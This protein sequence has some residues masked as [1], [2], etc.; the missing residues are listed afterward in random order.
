[1]RSKSAA[2]SRRPPQAR[3]SFPDVLHH[4]LRPN[5]GAVDVALSIGRDAFGGAGG[6]GVL[7]GIRNESRHLAIL[8]A[9][10]PDAALPVGARLVDRARLRIRY[11]D[12]VLL[13]YID[14][15]P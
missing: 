13:I 2:L 7:V 10:D 12:K 3:K 11:I 4:P 14:P 9:A 1:M 6:G 15:A 5:L 8:G